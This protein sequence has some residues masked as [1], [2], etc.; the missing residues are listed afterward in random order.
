[1]DKK[2]IERNLIDRPHDTQVTQGM[3]ATP[4]ALGP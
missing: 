1:M 2:L 4:Q 3:R